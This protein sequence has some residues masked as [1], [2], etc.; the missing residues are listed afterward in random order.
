MPQTG[1]PI[2]SRPKGRRI[3]TPRAMRLNAGE[4]RNAVREEITVRACAHRQN[5]VEYEVRIPDRHDPGRA[6]GNILSGSGSPLD[7]TGNHGRSGL[8]DGMK[9][10]SIGSGPSS[11]GS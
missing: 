2:H 5:P 7:R 4:I 3:S 8:R 11:D 1:L 6:K 10:D 9:G